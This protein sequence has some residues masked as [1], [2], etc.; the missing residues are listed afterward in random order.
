[1]KRCDISNS[2]FSRPVKKGLGGNGKF[3]IVGEASEP[4]W[5]SGPDVGQTMTGILVTVECPGVFSSTGADGSATNA[6]SQCSSSN[7]LVSAVF[8]SVRISLATS[9]LDQT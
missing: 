2:S 8:Q 3:C 4:V 7:V 9:P 1:S 6:E 5:S